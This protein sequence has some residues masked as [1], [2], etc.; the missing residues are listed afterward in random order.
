M[1]TR[2]SRGRRGTFLLERPQPKDMRETVL[3]TP[4]SQSSLRSGRGWFE[5]GPVTEPDYATTVPVTAALSAVSGSSRF[6][7][8]SS[9]MSKA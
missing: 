4:Q 2:R 1:K 6:L 7:N 8:H 3:A 9:N 5:L